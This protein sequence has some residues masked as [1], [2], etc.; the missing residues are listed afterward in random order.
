MFNMKC[1]SKRLHMVHWL[2]FNELTTNS[3]KLYKGAV[4]V[5]KLSVSLAISDSSLIGPS[6]SLWAASWVW[7]LKSPISGFL[8]GHSSSRWRV[9]RAALFYGPSL[10]LETVSNG[11]GFGWT[12]HMRYLDAGD[13][14]RIWSYQTQ[15][16]VGFQH[17]WGTIRTLTEFSAF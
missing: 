13:Q 6:K 4:W 15:I 17:C 12:R 7:D 2:P 14:V 1:H 3:P 11:A 5:V 9:V 10:Y 16:F 8:F